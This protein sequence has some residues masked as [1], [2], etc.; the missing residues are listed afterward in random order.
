VKALALLLVLVLTGCYGTG[1]LNT[2]SGRPEI[3]LGEV[4]QK[5]LFDALASWSAVR[6]RQV[7]SQTEYSLTTATQISLRLSPLQLIPSNGIA[8]TTF[9]PVRQNGIT[10]LFAQRIV[11]IASAL[12]TKVDD[13]QHAYEELQRDL[14]DFAGF[15]KAK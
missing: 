10:T 3:A 12:Q 8:K 9:T 5:E 6:G 4:S 11:D 7:V 15:L 1:K 13:T 14:E 2:A